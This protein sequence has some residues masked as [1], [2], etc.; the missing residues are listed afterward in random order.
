GAL[1]NPQDGEVDSASLVRA[2][3][4]AAASDT[5]SVRTG[6]EVRALTSG[7]T[8]VVLDTSAGEVRARS[9]LLAT[10]AYTR[11]LVPSTPIAPVRGQMLASAPAPE[12]AIDRPTY[13]NRGFQ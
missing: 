7:E 3:A 9:L 6:V 11:Q 1:L 10:N 13:A 8:A 12:V 5:A 2:L 4:A